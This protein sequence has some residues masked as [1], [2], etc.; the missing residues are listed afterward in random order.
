[1]ATAGTPC[2]WH[3]AW[4]RKC[5]STIRLKQAIQSVVRFVGRFDGEDGK[6]NRLVP[7]SDIAPRKVYSPV[8]VDALLEKNQAIPGEQGTWQADLSTM[9]SI[10]FAGWSASGGTWPCPTDNC[11]SASPTHTMKKRLR[12]WC[13]GTDAWC[14]AF[15]GSSFTIPMTLKTRS[16]Q[17]FSSSLGRPSRLGRGI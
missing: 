13:S 2:V 12:L 11:W 8:P 5:T 17:P 10:T 3:H 9:S 14:S 6:Q 4:L 7:A 15:A 16:R 1:M